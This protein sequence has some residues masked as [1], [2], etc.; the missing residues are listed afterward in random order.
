MVSTSIS[1][2][3]SEGKK[4]GMKSIF[5]FKSNIGER[6]AAASIFPAVIIGT[7]FQDRGVQWL[8]SVLDT[9]NQAASYQKALFPTH[10]ATSSAI[11]KKDDILEPICLPSLVQ[12]SGGED[13]RYLLCHC[14]SH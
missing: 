4:P 1:I 12:S 14:E 9:V 10:K 13:Q 7:L 11:H 6:E 5:S 8:S 2:V 3:L